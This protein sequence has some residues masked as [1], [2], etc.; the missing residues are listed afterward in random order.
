MARLA[1]SETSEHNLYDSYSET[2]TPFLTNRNIEQ[3]PWG[4][5]PR[6]P[7]NS[8]LK[9]AD[10]KLNV[11]VIFEP[12]C[13][14]SDLEHVND[15]QGYYLGTTIEQLIIVSQTL[16]VLRGTLNEWESKIMQKENLLKFNTISQGDITLVLN[17][18]LEVKPSFEDGE[19]S[20]SI[21]E[22]NI[23]ISAPTLG[24]AGDELQSDIIWLWREYVDVQDEEITLDAQQLRE[25]L[26]NLVK[27]VR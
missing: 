9:L 17:A 10:P 25:K 16:G 7:R 5:R 20:L 2:I 26:Q 19:Y 1:I 22:L 11:S 18:P 3:L 4:M 14:Y 8:G 27:E 15:S 6:I 12:T 21:P 23:Y 13:S 24:D